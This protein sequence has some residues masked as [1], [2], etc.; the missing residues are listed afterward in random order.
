[1]RDM[2]KAPWTT[3]ASIKS[4]LQSLLMLNSTSTTRGIEEP[5]VRLLIRARTGDQLA[6]EFAFPY[7]QQIHE[8]LAAAMR[9]FPG[10]RRAQ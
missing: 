7:W 5:I 9:E 8:V 6:V 1:M 3:E 10:G 4:A 2:E